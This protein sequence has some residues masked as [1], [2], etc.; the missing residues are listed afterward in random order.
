MGLSADRT[1]IQEYFSDVIMAERHFLRS[2]RMFSLLNWGLS[3]DIL[4]CDVIVL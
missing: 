3:C 2:G 4:T 1:A